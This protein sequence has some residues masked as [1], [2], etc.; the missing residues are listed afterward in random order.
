MIDPRFYTV[1]APIDVAAA[2]ELCGGNCFRENMTETH[3]KGVVA[4]GSASMDGMAVYLTD[5]AHLS[6]IGNGAPALVLTTE[7]LAEKVSEHFAAPET[8]IVTVRNPRAS[9]ALLANYFHQ[10]IEETNF[11]TTSGKANKYD[12]V[13]CTLS[14]KF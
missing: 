12:T 2:I 9:F 13:F 10:S 5:K 6:N 8:C 1:N 7:K 4:A 3:V 11:R 14:G